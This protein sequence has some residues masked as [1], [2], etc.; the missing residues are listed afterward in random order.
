MH[1]PS[2]NDNVVWQDTD[3]AVWQDTDNVVWQDTDNV[4]WQDTDIA[5][6]QDTDSMVWQGNYIFYFYKVILP[7]LDRVSCWRMY[8]IQTTCV[9]LPFAYCLLL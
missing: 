7:F 2:Y 4:V 6:W 3:N 8:K 5:V 1:K 9:T